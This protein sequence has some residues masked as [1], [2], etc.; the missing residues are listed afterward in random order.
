MHLSLTGTV[1]QCDILKVKK[2]DSYLVMCDAIKKKLGRWNTVE[3]SDVLDVAILKVCGDKNDVIL[4]KCCDENVISK[5]CGDEDNVIL[6]DCDEENG[7]MLEECGDEDVILK[8]HGD[9]NIIL[10]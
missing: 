10:K 9:K 4:K 8:E 5:E 3:K 6:K 1:K 2:L 7:V